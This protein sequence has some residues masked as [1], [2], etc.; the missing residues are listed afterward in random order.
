MLTSEMKASRNIDDDF[1]HPL[2]SN[3]LV[4]PKELET[5]VADRYCHRLATERRDYSIAE[6]QSEQTA[7]FAY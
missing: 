6:E 2:S 5:D 3:G 7:C 4:G 1:L